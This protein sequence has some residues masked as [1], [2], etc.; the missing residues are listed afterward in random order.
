[1]TFCPAKNCNKFSN[2][3]RALTE[4]IIKKA[5]KWFGSPNAPISR[6]SEPEKLHCFQP[7]TT[8]NNNNNSVI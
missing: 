5:E 3:P 2:C 1:M 4:E 6:F 7:I 8:G